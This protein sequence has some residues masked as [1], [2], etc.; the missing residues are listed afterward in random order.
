[1]KYDIVKKS[2]AS[3]SFDSFKL[4]QGFDNAKNYIK[5]NP[6]VRDEIMKK[7]KEAMKAGEEGK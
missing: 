1:M 4:G 7:I 5:E 6:K 3:L 2:G